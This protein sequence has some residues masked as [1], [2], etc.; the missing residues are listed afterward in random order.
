ML[1]LGAIF[2]DLFRQSRFDIS[3]FM[4]SG[5]LLS[6]FGDYL[7][8]TSNLKA[9]VINVCENVYVVFVAHLNY[10]LNYDSYF[11]LLLKTGLYCTVSYL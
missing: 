9:L 6:F 3:E 8:Y 11:Y 7:L 4:N 1:N 2:I 10:D 5:V